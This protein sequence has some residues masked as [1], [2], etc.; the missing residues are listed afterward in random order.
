MR[1]CVSRKRIT[2]RT[3]EV[4]IVKQLRKAEHT[5]RA[6]VSAV[7][8]VVVVALQTE[9]PNSFGHHEDSPPVDAKKRLSCVAAVVFM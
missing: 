8:A 2:T 1:D 4:K 9:P 7:D 5:A 6:V 3:P